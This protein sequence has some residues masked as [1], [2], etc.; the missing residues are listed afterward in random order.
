MGIQIC[1]SVSNTKAKTSEE[2]QHGW[3]RSEE[4][5]LQGI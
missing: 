1:Y 5:Q 2:D 4:I 3:N